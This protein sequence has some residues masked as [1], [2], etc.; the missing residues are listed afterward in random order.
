M[1]IVSGKRLF[2]DLKDLVFIGNLP[3][4]VI[5]DMNPNGSYKELEE[6]KNKEA[7]EYLK[8]RPEIIDYDYLNTLSEE[9]IYDYIHSLY[10]EYFDL[11]K[12]GKD[13]YLERKMEICEYKVSEL[14]KYIDYK[15]IYDK[16]YRKIK[17][18]QKM[19]EK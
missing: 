2:V 14:K 12:K 9:A 17:L 5:E 1:R 8:N 15:K 13:F 16:K 19:K 3:N 6:F 18:L 11:Y 4:Y 7:I 10:E